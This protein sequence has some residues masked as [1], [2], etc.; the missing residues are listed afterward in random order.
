MAQRKI[1]SFVDDLDGGEATQTV[2]FGLDGVEYA[3]DLSDKNADD[4][5][6]ALAPFAA[7]GRKLS[8]S[9]RPYRLVKLGP[10]A[11]DLRA[12]AKSHGLD[13]PERG[14]VPRSVQEAYDK[15]HAA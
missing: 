15:A 13:V 3:I 5:R 12:W 14:R 11:R 4:L 7:K 2:K 9:G 8:R 6:E 10:S 1:V